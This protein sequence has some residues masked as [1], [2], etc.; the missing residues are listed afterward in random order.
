[1]GSPT[2]IPDVPPATPEE[3]PPTAWWEWPFVAVFMPVVLL[4]RTVRRIPAAAR[5][6]WACARSRS[7]DKPDADRCAG[8][9]ALACRLLR[10]A[11]ASHRGRV[12]G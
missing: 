11:A 7:V 2:P 4:M 6:V 10:G 12:R 3:M 1:M 5:M 8:A 9:A